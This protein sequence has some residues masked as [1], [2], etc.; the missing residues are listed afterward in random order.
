MRKTLKFVIFFCFAGL[1][2]MFLNYP[3]V[4]AQQNTVVRCHFETSQIDV[5]GKTIITLE[6]LDVTDLFAFQLDM[7]FDSDLVAVSG[8]PDDPEYRTAWQRR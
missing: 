3:I 7:A 5:G 4:R 6:V 1:F 8:S 2:L